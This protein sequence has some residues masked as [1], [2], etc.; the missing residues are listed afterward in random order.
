MWHTAVA[1]TFHGRDIFAPVAAY[2][3]SGG[4][5]ENVGPTIDDP[6][7]LAVPAPQ[8]SAEHVVGLVVHIDRFGNLITNIPAAWMRADMVVEAGGHVIGQ[9]R[10]TY[11]DVRLGD[12]VAVIGSRGMLELSVRDGNAAVMLALGRHDTVR[13]RIPGAK[14]V[15]H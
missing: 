5:P 10:T 1:P 14:G 6:V 4:L 15:S 11:A 13:C 8:R 12:V 9:M 7:R 3:A 2:L